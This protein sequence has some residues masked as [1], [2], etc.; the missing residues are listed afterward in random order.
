MRR[1]TP[2]A[3]AT[4]CAVFYL[5]A[6]AGVGLTPTAEKIAEPAAVTSAV[7]ASSETEAS[8]CHC[9]ELD[10]AFIAPTESEA[11][12]IADTEQPVVQSP[13]LPA[14]LRAAKVSYKPVPKADVLSREVAAENA[15]RRL[16]RYLKNAGET[17]EGWRKYLELS[18]LQEALD[19]GV[20]LQPAILQGYIDRF[21]DG[22]DGLELP[23]FASVRNA[24]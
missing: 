24:L 9:P 17:G 13:D 2:Y 1:L 23:Q 4:L 16:D 19:K 14:K 15:V 18:K 10:P 8:G 7:A 3:A 6:Q 11:T 5:Y 22:S 12:V 20:A 21:S